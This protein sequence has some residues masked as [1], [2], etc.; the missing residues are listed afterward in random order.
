MGSQTYDCVFKQVV[1][2]IKAKKNENDYAFSFNDI[3]SNMSYPEESS[4][5]ETEA[6]I[7]DALKSL[8]NAEVIWRINNHFFSKEPLLRSD[9]VAGSPKKEIKLLQEEL[10]EIQKEYGKTFERLHKLGADLTAIKQLLQKE[11]AVPD[12]FRVLSS[13]EVERLKPEIEQKVLEGIQEGIENI[14]A[15]RARKRTKSKTK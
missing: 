15:F 10:V 12:P 8:Q 4:K 2:I 1:E 6:A 3:A 11:Q 13:E 9:Y 5:E 7:W 14:Q